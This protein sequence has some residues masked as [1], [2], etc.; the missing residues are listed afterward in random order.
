VHAAVRAREVGGEVEEPRLAHRQRVVQPDFDVPM[1]VEGGN[2]F[3]QPAGI[4]VVEQ[5]AHAHAALRGSP[6][7]VVQQVPGLVAVPDV[8]LDVERLVGGG[9]KQ[10]ACGKRVCRRR[11]RVNAGLARMRR[12]TGFEPRVRA[13]LRSCRPARVTRRGRRAAEALRIPR[14][15]PRLR[16]SQSTRCVAFAS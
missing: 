6:H 3:V 15:A 8:V 2:R 14:P 13:V 7:R 4:R 16:Q 10:H 12:D 9:R 5:D 1:R 11:E